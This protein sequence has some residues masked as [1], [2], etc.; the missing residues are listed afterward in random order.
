MSSQEWKLAVS[1]SSTRLPMKLPLFCL[2]LLAIGYA[3]QPALP[4]TIHEIAP[5][6]MVELRVAWD[7][8]MWNDVCCA[9]NNIPLMRID[10]RTRRKYDTNNELI[11]M[12]RSDA[13]IADPSARTGQD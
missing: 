8:S 6:P 4:D 12:S 10:G 11:F 2:L 7:G 1:L 13:W 3:Q 9:P 5:L